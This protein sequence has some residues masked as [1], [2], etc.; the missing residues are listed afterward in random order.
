MKNYLETPTF[1][2]ASTPSA[3][4]GHAATA[5]WRG[6]WEMQSFSWVHAALPTIKVLLLRRSEDDVKMGSQQPWPLTSRKSTSLKVW[7]AERQPEG[8]L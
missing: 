6:R 5:K 2:F 8:H 4:R 7:S 1:T 3:E